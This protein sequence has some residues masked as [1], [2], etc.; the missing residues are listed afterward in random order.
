[1]GVNV[2]VRPSCAKCN[3]VIEIVIPVDGLNEWSSGTSRH[4]QVVFPDLTPAERE[5]FISRICGSCWNKIFDEP[6][7]TDEDVTL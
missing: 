5:M 1:M 7:E 3:E 2:T 4:I 6:K